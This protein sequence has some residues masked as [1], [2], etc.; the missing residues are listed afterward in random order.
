MA[1]ITDRIRTPANSVTL[2]SGERGRTLFDR[3]SLLLFALV[4]V[5]ILFTFR[6]YGVT[7]DEPL[8]RYYG[9]TVCRYYYLLFTG[10]YTPFESILIPDPWYQ[11]LNYYGALFHVLTTAASAVSPFREYETRHL[12]NAFAGL[13]GIVGCWKAARF[14]AGPSAGFWAALLLTLTPRYYGAMFNNQK[15][16]PFAAAYI[17][18]MYYLLRIIKELPRLRLELVLKAGVV[19]GLTIS[20]RVG[21]LLLLCYLALVVL[22]Y[23]VWLIWR[24][25]F[26]STTIRLLLELSARAAAVA[27]IAWVITLSAWPWLHPQPMTRLFRALT[28]LSSKY[29]WTGNELFEGMYYKAT[30]LPRHYIPKWLWIT[31]PE[32]VLAI[33]IVGAVAAAGTLIARR[34]SI[35]NYFWWSCG[36]LAFSF[37]FPLVYALVTRPVMYDA[38]R[39]FFFIV[40]PLVCLSGIAFSQMTR[41]LGDH[42]P[43]AATAVLALTSAYLVYDASVMIRLHP[44]EYVYFNRTVGGLQTAYGKYETDYWGNSYREAVLKL[45]DFVKAEPAGKTQPSYKIMTE[46]K[47]ESSTWYFPSN[48]AFTN[49]PEEADFFISTTRDRLHES[50][51]GNVILQV[52]RFHTPLAIVKDRRDRKG[53][54]PANWRN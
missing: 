40:P 46:S 18:S 14:V 33:L 34:R 32:L 53:T 48:F 47:R 21:G 29:P 54:R 44:D 3:A 49:K 42:H 41:W 9:R 23:A 5:G 25:G 12:V 1:A 27:G 20:A 38:A 11:L 6:D 17:W 2:A 31:L 19:I 50:V 4:A 30:A 39:H 13:A 16:I 36:L 10:H 37:C 8:D 52:E 15:D 7:W 26:Q 43:S 28:G 45:V 51:D 35:E 24:S 22:L